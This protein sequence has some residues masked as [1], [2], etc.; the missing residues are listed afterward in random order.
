MRME[1]LIEKRDYWQMRMD[2]AQ[3]LTSGD[4]ALARL[5]AV[6]LKQHYQGMDAAIERFTHARSKVEYYKHRIALAKARQAK[7]SRRVFTRDDLEG[8]TQIRTRHGWHR[9][10]RVNAKTVTVA[11]DYSWT[12]RYRHDE[13]LEIATAPAVTA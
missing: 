4:P 6:A 5:D 2:C 11:T 8:V 13:I 9:V 10:L 7:A 1:E 12:D 3:P